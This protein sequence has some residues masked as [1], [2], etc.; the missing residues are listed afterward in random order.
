[1]DHP[2]YKDSLETLHRLIETNFKEQYQPT[3]LD[4]PNAAT[5]HA[6]M[7]KKEIDEAAEAYQ[8]SLNRGLQVLSTIWQEMKKEGPFP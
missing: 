6:T 7:K 2:L 3:P 5:Y 4:P 1:M 8:K